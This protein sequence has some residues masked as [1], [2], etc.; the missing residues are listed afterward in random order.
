[1]LSS[2]AEKEAEL[3]QALGE[4]ISAGRHVG[5]LVF[6]VDGL[7]GGNWRINGS[8]SSSASYGSEASAEAGFLDVAEDE[9]DENGAGACWTVPA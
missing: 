1:M 4:S 9:A 2:L 3:L 8:S 6:V 5:W 7:A